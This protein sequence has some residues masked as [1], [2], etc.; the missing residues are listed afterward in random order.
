MGF[1]SWLKTRKGE[2]LGRLFC[3]RL[4]TDNPQWP[5][6]GETVE[7]FRAALPGAGYDRYLDKLWARYQQELL[8]PVAPGPGFF[9]NPVL[10][11]FHVR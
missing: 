6:D 8:K 7:I 5:E 10:D 11:P 4:V 9:G 1:T 2:D 3:E